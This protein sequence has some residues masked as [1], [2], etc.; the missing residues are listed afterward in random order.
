MLQSY[1]RAFYYISSS[2]WL[3]KKLK[4][5]SLTLVALEMGYKSEQVVKT[6]DENLQYGEPMHYKKE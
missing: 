4:I 3:L 2:N 5:S 6:V 1:T